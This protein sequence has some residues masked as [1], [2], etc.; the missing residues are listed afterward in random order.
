[1]M[2]KSIIW[3]NNNPLKY[4]LNDLAHQMFPEA[5]LFTFV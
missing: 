1:M 2:E 3:V 4:L 5:F